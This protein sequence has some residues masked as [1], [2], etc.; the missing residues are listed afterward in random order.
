MIVLDGI[1]VSILIR[2]DVLDFP[3]SCILCGMEKSE[4]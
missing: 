1:V 2:P 4:T 3:L